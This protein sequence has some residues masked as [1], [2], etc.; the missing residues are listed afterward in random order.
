MLSHALF[1]TSSNL[2][3]PFFSIFFISDIAGVTVR[4][5]GIS[6]L[7]F[8][9]SFGLLEPVMG[10]ISDHIP[11][12]KDEVM[13][14]IFGYIVRGVLFASFAFATNIW[15]LYMFHFFLGA[16]RAVSGPADKVLY[17]KYLK[18][19]TS[20]TL[21]GLDE[22]V[23]NVSS[24]LGAGLGGY[25]ISLYGFRY[26]FLVVGALTVLS[27]LINFPLLRSINRPGR[28]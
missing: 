25:M 27:G 20:A 3:T 8:S 2:I 14:I 1:W 10:F 5:I 28:S 26:V 9:L 6:A 23:M 17:A 21:W 11:G 24:A 7:I 16:A 12:L 22:S 19:R 15:Q 18:G 4:E 13:F